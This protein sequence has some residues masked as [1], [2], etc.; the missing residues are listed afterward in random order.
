MKLKTVLAATAALSLAAPA[1]AAEGM[2][3]FDGFPVARANAFLGTKIDQKWLDRVRQSAVRIPGCS[4]SLVSGEGLILTNNHCV[5]GCAQDLSTPQQ[6]YV[7]RGFND[8]DW[9]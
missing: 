9:L 7:N 3:T 1:L 5:I 4:A 8:I 2:W 6:D